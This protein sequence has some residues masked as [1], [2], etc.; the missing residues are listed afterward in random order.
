MCT[1]SLK[2]PYSSGIFAF[3]EVSLFAVTAPV[4]ADFGVNVRNV[5]LGD[6]GGVSSWARLAAVI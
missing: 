4:D 6:F 2:P 3:L 1:D 5:S